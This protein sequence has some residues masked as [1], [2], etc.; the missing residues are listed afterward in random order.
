ML[1]KIKRGEWF[2]YTCRKD[3]GGNNAEE[4]FEWKDPAI[5]LMSC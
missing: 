1:L 2:H 4:I 5:A 3:E